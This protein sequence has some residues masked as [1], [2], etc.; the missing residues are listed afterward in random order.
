LRKAPDCSRSIPPGSAFPSC[1][2][3]LIEQFSS[4]LARLKRHPVSV[5]RAMGVLM[6]LTGVGFLTGSMSS[7]SIW[8]LETFPA[9]QNF[10]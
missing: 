4:L 1:W 9:L 8:L 5:E 2:L 6:V 3:P 10:G 7:I